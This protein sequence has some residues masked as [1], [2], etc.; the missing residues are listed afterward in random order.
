MVKSVAGRLPG[1]PGWPVGGLG[2]AFEASLSSHTKLFLNFGALENGPSRWLGVAR[3]LP[4]CPVGLGRLSGPEAVAGTVAR[5]S[6]NFILTRQ[7]SLG[8]ELRALYFYVCCLS[9]PVR[10]ASF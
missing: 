1:S 8:W 3:R 2:V 4:G 5:S 7:G 6:D 10:W 9:V